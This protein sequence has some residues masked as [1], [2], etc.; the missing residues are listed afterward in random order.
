MLVLRF[1]WLTRIK[2]LI[3]QRSHFFSLIILIAACSISLF[4]LAVLVGLPAAYAISGSA[5]TMHENIIIILFSCPYG[6]FT[7]PFGD[8]QPVNI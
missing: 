5:D 8:P 1:F 2:F 7:L 4:Y 6:A 3:V